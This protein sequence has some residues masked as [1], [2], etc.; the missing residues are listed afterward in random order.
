MEFIR[1]KLS[2]CY[3]LPLLILSAILCCRGDQQFQ[4][5]EKQILFKLDSQ[6]GIPIIR[7]EKT[8]ANSKERN[9]TMVSLCNRVQKKD[10]E[11][12]ILSIN[13]IFENMHIARYLD[14]IQDIDLFIK[15]EVGFI[16]EFDFRGSEMY[17]NSLQFKQKIMHKVVS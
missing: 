4:Q 10:R 8:N 14:Y 17:Y 1:L 7:G 6:H 13:Q 2:L 15:N 5:H 16:E 12:C 11:Q 3:S 9:H